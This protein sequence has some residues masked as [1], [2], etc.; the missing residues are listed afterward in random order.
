MDESQNF[1]H[2][3]IFYIHGKNQSHKAKIVSGGLFLKNMNKPA[4]HY[5]SVLYIA[6][7]SGYIT[8]F[9]GLMINNAFFD[10]PFAIKI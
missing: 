9:T 3:V 5:V 1:Y 10:I 6:V 7:L 4:T 2:M 8:N